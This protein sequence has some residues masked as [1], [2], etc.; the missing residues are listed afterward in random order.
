ME[1]WL[2]IRGFSTAGQWMEVYKNIKTK[3]TKKTKSLHKTLKRK[4]ES[5]TSNETSRKVL[6]TSTGES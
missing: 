3:T 4:G 5:R 1:L 2:T 6:K